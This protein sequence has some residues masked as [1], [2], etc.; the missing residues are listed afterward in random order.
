MLSNVLQ[1]RSRQT[2]AP[3]AAQL[4]QSAEVISLAAYR[5]RA[6]RLRT[7]TGVY[8]VSRDSVPPEGYTAA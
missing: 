4:A 6:R 8:F 5:N 1:F 2:S 3:A 7:A